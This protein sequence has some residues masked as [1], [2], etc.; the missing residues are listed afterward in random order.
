MQQWWYDFW[1]WAETSQLGAN[2][3]G[4]IVVAVLVGLGTLAITVVPKWRKPSSAA[5]RRAWTFLTS[6]RL[7]TATQIEAGREEVR[8]EGV[9]PFAHLLATS[10]DGNEGTRTLREVLVGTSPG[11]QKFD[12]G[13][14]A[15]ID[16][17]LSPP[18]LLADVPTPAPTPT[19]TEPVSWSARKRADGMIVVTNLSNKDAALH[20]DVSSL[21]LIM[22]PW[23]THPSWER[24][25]PRQSGTF[26]AMISPGRKLPAVVLKLVWEGEDG[27][28]HAAHVEVVGA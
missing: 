19:A 16:D 7:T 14:L 22:E 28:A 10:P 2:V 11:P 1:E 24:I 8:Q 17:E 27:R 23:G 9:N 15:K 13:K 20:V 4:G 12:F 25:E 21:G 18:V 6:I 5:V 26:K 3:V